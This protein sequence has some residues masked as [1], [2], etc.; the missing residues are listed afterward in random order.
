MFRANGNE[1]DSRIQQ[2]QG[3]FGSAHIGG[4]Q[5]LDWSESSKP[6]RQLK[7]YF[8]PKDDVMRTTMR[9]TFVSTDIL[10]V[11][12][13]THIHSY[14]CDLE[15]SYIILFY[16][17][18]GLQGSDTQNPFSHMDTP[19]LLSPSSSTTLLALLGLFPCPLNNPLRALHLGLLLLG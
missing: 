19:P 4:A 2:P 14:T 7:E 6:D 3:S 1:A 16:Y 8:S 5:R 17:S 18:N 9:Y 12:M 13:C 10:S 11:H 15:S